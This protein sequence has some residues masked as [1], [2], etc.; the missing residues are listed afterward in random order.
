[1]EA[2]THLGMLPSFPLSEGD[3]S[4]VPM[5]AKVLSSP[6]EHLHFSS[7]HSASG[8]CFSALRLF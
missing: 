2:A 3:I 6:G 5:A 7:L 4:R 1:M 8:D